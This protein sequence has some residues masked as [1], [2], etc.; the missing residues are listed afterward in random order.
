M[1]GPD[2]AGGAT[3]PSLA[4]VPRPA[5]DL[6]EA[7]GH[8]QQDRNEEQP[9]G[10]QE[11]FECDARG[12][13]FLIEGELSGGHRDREGQDASDQVGARTPQA[14]RTIEDAL[15]VDGIVPSSPR[16][17]PPPAPSRRRLKVPAD[18][19]QRSLQPG[20]RLEQHIARQGEAERDDRNV[21]KPSSHQRCGRADQ[22]PQCL[23]PSRYSRQRF[24]DVRPSAGWSVPLERDCTAA[25]R[26]SVFVRR[27]VG[28]RLPRTG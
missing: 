11:E 28:D 16:E 3:G 18:S 12:H 19:G 4:S 26:A 6:V 1:R 24:D 14:A 15:A 23:P 8:R 13:G 10:K 21:A 25:K 22:L 7:H 5:S 20:G 9:Q 17:G 27:Q 2:F